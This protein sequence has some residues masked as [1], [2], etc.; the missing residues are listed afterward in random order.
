MRA[1][2]HIEFRGSPTSGG[3]ALENAFTEGPES[4]SAIPRV[5]RAA[6]SHRGAG[7]RM[8]VTT[9]RKSSYEEG[10]LDQYLRDISIYPLISRDEEVRLAHRISVNDQRALDQLV[11]TNYSC[12]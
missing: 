10:S 2:P 5:P 11:R 3:G 8:G 4:S 7:A 12:V 6:T 1:T 9:H